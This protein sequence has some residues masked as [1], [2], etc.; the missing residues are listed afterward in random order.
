M[1]VNVRLLL[2]ALV[3]LLAAPGAGAVT[4]GSLTITCSAGQCGRFHAWSCTGAVDLDELTVVVDVPGGAKGKAR[5]GVYLGAGCTGRIGRLVVRTDGGDGIKVAG[6][7]DLTVGGGSVSCDGRWRDVHQDGIQVMG[8][9]RITFTGLAV[10]CTTANDAQLRISQG[11][12][13]TEPPADVVCDSCSFRPG[14]GAF[15]DVTIGVSTHSG[16]VRSVVCPAR[17][18][19]LV[20][21]VRRATDPLDEQNEFPASC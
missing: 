13:M 5:D 12:T 7:H 3:A 15:H 4:S 16:A 17:S 6:A 18:P 20:Y 10:A 8:G 11:G 19:R 21:D 2:T 1:T 9:R 14:P